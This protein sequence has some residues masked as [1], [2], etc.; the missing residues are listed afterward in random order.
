MA[1]LIGNT[2]V[3]TNNGA[4]GSVDGN[5]LNLATNA[6]IAAGGATYTVA[7]TTTNTDVAGNNAAIIMVTAGGG[8]ANSRGDNT[9]RCMGA[10]CGGYTNVTITGT[11]NNAT[12]TVGGAAGNSNFAG[13]VGNFSAIAGPSGS[14]LSA[15]FWPSNSADGQSGLFGIRGGN[16]NGGSQGATVPGGALGGGTIW[17]GVGT[18]RPDGN[19]AAQGGGAGAS[20]GNS[21]NGG[22]AGGA[23][24]V[25]VIGMG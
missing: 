5:N 13:T 14:Q 20:G 16:G 1:Y 8:N 11:I 9:D 17:N 25:A 6:N 12:L 23:G 15:G 18:P 7:N 4:L 24:R 21:K 3:I 22:R 2:T 10:G 19:A